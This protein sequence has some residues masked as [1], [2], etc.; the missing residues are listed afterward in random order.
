MKELLSL[1]ENGFICPVRKIAFRELPIKRLFRIAA[2][3][4][5][6]EGAALLYPSKGGV[7]YRVQL[8]DYLSRQRPRPL[9]LKDHPT[10]DDSLLFPK[11]TMKL[12]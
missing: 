6:T 8:V 9:L 7:S 2:Y 3:E 11:T 12:V 4:E 5:L 1:A 10:E